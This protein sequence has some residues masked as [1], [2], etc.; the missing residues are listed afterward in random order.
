MEEW[1]GSGLTQA[2][3]C[4]RRKVNVGSFGWWKRRFNETLRL[5]R[6]RV[7]RTANRQPAREA[8]SFVEL[9]LPNGI[10]A[11]NLVAPPTSATGPYGYEIALSNGRVIRLPHDFDPTTVAQ[12]VAAIESC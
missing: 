12:L 10:R 5:P 3:F 2:E 4:R 7:R 11:R 1:K 9:A 8:A 6:R